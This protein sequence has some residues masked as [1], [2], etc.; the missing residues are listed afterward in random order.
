M[1]ENKKLLTMVRFQEVTKKAS[2]DEVDRAILISCSLFP[3]LSIV[4]GSKINY[5]PPWIT[6]VAAQF[7]S[8]I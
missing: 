1:P 2:I 4:L 7:V 3:C 5:Y 8:V 6:T